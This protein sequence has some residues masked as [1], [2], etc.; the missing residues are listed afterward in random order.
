MKESELKGDIMR[1]WV[2]TQEKRSF[3]TWFLQNHRLKRTE[4]RH[5]L[6]FMIKQHH[7]LENLRFTDTVKRNVT[8][9][10]ISSINS[11]EIGFQ[12]IKNNRKSEDVSKAMGE[13]M[14][15]P[16]IEIFLLLHFHGKQMNNRYLNIFEDP[17]IENIRRYNITEKFS[18]EAER[19]IDQSIEENK[20]DVLRKR[21]DWALDN[22]DKELFQR[23]T[24]E[25]RVL[26]QNS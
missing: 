13:L 14:A 26:E 19:L 8:T 7:I 17:L 21:I 4:A 6:E 16:S 1:K 12:F 2:S 5:L 15:D 18:K 20:L 3:L 25:L 9:V 23:L 10:V 22:K 24:A 11:D